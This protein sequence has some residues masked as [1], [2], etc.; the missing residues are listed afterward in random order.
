MP[1]LVVAKLKNLPPKSHP[2]MIIMWPSTLSE[3][4]PTQMGLIGK[5]IP[6]I[7]LTKCIFYLKLFI[8]VKHST[9]F[10]RSFRPSSGAKN[11]AYSNGKCQTAAATCCYRGWYIKYSLTTNLSSGLDSKTPLLQVTSGIDSQW[12][13]CSK[14]RVFLRWGVVFI[15]WDVNIQIS[16]GERSENFQSVPKVLCADCRSLV[17][18]ECAENHNAQVLSNK[19]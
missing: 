13:S 14:I 18:S 2:V 4:R 7:K 12:I 8:L 5:N 17:C 1:L 11:C 10:G 15:K 19:Q 16:R 9:C 3:W 6:I